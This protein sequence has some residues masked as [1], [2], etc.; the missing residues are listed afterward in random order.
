MRTITEN[1]TPRQQKLYDRVAPKMNSKSAFGFAAHSY[2]AVTL[3]AAAVKQAGTTDGVKVREAL[4]NLQA[5]Y[6]G[7]MKS[8]NKP[9]SKTEHEALLSPDYKWTKWKD[10]K[11]IAYSDEIIT[12][13]KPI[14][15]KK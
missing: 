2:D 10:G 4:E 6:D 13:L 12:S 8:Y 11:L 3:F 9:F 15:F 7:L 14:D 1:R 5:S